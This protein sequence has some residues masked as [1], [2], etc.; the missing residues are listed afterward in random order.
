MEYYAH[1][2]Y[3]TKPKNQVEDFAVSLL[4]SMDKDVVTDK[5]REEDEKYF[6]L[7]VEEELKENKRVKEVHINSYKSLDNSYVLSTDH[8]RVVYYPI[9]KKD[10]F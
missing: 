2:Q 4:K 5:E 9:V 1:Y 6:R 3:F 8:A 7:M 10:R